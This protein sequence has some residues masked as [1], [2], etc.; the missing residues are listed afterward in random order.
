MAIKIRGKSGSPKME[1]LAAKG[2][3]VGVKKLRKILHIPPETKNSKAKPMVSIRMD[4]QTLEFFKGSGPG[5]QTRINDI[6]R[7]Y[8]QAQMKAVE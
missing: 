6:L 8:V 2:S 1:K 4:A 7:N 5:W 3:V